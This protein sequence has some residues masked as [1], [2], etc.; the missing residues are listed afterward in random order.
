M[1]WV[2]FTGRKLEA[3]RGQVIYQ[4]LGN[5]MLHSN[6]QP[7]HLIIMH[8]CLLREFIVL[9]GNILIDTTLTSVKAKEKIIVPESVVHLQEI[10]KPCFTFILLTEIYSWKNGVAQSLCMWEIVGA[11]DPLWHDRKKAW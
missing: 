9:S 1:S 8:Y 2:Y 10:T 11:F 6:R 3:K 5:A 4:H 7:S